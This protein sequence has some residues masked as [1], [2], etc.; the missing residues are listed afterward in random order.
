ML[1]APAPPGEPPDRRRRLAAAAALTALA[2]AL[3]VLLTYTWNRWELLVVAALALGAAVLSGWYVLTRRGAV[4][5]VAAVAGAV[6]LVMFLGVL[7]GGGSVAV[8]LVAAALGSGSVAAAEVALG[9]PPRPAPPLSPAPAGRHPVLL[10]N[11]RSG[12][13]KARTFDLPTECRRR[14]IEP[15]V[16][17]PGDDLLAR[18][19]RA[20]AEGADVLGM[21]GGDGS[22]GVVA[23]VAAAHGLPFVVVPA[24]TRNHFALDLGLDRTDVVGALDAYGDGVDRR[25]DLGRVDDRP[26]VNNASMGVYARVVQSTEYRDAKVATAAAVLPDV[27]G[28]GAAPSPLRFTT[29]EGEDVVGAQLLLVSN[30]PY[31]LRT[32]RGAGTRDRLDGGVLGVV[33][34]SVRGPAD[35]E[36]F[37]ALEAVGEVQRFA[38]W[39]EWT[40]PRLVV[41]SSEPVAVGLDGE[42]VLLAPPLVFEVRPAA[43]VVRVPRR[44]VLQQRGPSVRVT[45]PS[46][47]RQLWEVARG[48]PATRPVAP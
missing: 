15:I 33:A 14:G 19:E 5:A 12:G 24:G 29:P 41:G 27:L 28:P 7:L 21:A 43:L 30:N 11:L 36:R 23:S 46:T 22:L 17:E 39:R 6:A 3:L 47:W 25:V 48:R 45:A 9:H 37:A 32:L 13:G 34:V 4:R 42:A 40:T 10:M 2:A 31:R 8:L 44:V 20:V 38:G 1:P 16:L 26:F 35:V 18:A